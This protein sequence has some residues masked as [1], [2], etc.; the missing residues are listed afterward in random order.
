M[1]VG[2][3]WTV[4]SI[5]A[6]KIGALCFWVETAWGARR[7]TSVVF[8]TGWAFDFASAVI[9]PFDVDA[10]SGTFSEV[11]AHGIAHRTSGLVFVFGEANVF[12]ASFEVWGWVNDI[13]A[14]GVHNVRTKHN[15][16]SRFSHTFGS[17]HVTES[18]FRS[19]QAF[20]A[21]F[22]GIGKKSNRFDDGSISSG[23]I[24]DLVM[25]ENTA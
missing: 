11:S 10:V 6:L 3:E 7:S 8:L 25:I 9:P 20:I 13:F 19:F 17:S 5:D 23:E 24:I 18:F 4:T 1:R 12:F 14:F 15:S 2:V 22:P 16:L 21:S